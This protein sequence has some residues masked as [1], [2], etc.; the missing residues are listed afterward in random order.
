MDMETLGHVSDLRTQALCMCTHFR[1]P[2]TMKGKFSVL[3]LRFGMNPTSSRSHSKPPFFQYKKPYMVPFQNIEK[4]LKENKRFT[5]NNESKREFFTKHPQ[6]NIFRL[7][8]FLALI[9]EF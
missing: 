9:F 5:R 4:I 1:F 7:G 3:K 6:V 8:P 2:E